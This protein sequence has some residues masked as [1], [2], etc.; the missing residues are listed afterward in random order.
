MGWLKDIAN[1]F[2][3]GIAGDVVEGVVSAKAARRARRF[4]ERM[5]S[6][7]HQREVA[8]LRAAGLNP[9]LSATGGP[10]ASTPNAPVANVPNFGDAARSSRI[11]KA[12]V[13]NVEADTAKKRSEAALVEAQRTQ[14]V[15]DIHKK[16]ADTRNVNIDADRKEFDRPLWKQFQSADWEKR[17]SD[18]ARATFDAKSSGLEARRAEL[19]LERLLKQP[20]LL[21]Y[22]M[23][24]DYAK[25]KRIDRMIEGGA[26]WGE[27]GRA[28]LEIFRR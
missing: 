15:A 27:V 22:L 11:V 24:I 17:I 19:E 1:V 6:T 9:I 16:A 23:S 25:A 20:E 4:E 18:A 26:S 12:Q 21:D 10:G 3:G 14:T 28:I 8:D 7:A 2:T 5:S 13:E